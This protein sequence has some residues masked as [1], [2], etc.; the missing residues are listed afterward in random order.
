[1]DFE[2][3]KQWLLANN[4]AKLVDTFG[5]VYRGNEKEYKLEQQSRELKYIKMSCDIPISLHCTCIK[6]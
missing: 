1:M 3:V 2:L 5:G 4:L 6:S